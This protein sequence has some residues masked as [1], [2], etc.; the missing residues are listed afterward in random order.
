MDFNKSGFFFEV[1]QDFIRANCLRVEARTNGFQGGD[2]G[3][4]SW[5]EV[6]FLNLGGTDL[7]AKIEK[8]ANGTAKKVILE[9]AGDSELETLADSLVFA[10]EAL[11]KAIALQTGEAALVDEISFFIDQ[12][13]GGSWEGSATQLLAILNEQ[14]EYKGEHPQN[15]HRWPGDAGALSLKLG[16]SKLALMSKK[17]GFKRRRTKNGSE[18]ILWREQEG[19]DA[20][21]S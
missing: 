9:V 14:L 21:Q 15:K 13:G 16:A 7:D 18:F 1:G 5:A 4:G 11:K 20:D 19:D 10:G 17:I 8:E 12:I 6:C 3:H 2:A